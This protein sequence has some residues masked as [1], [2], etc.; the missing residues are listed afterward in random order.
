MAGHGGHAAPG[1]GVEY[2]DVSDDA[3]LQ[4]RSHRDIALANALFGGSRAVLA[5]FAGILPSAGGQVTLLDVG[6]GTGDIPARLA[7]HAA[8][9]G[10]DLRVCGLDGRLELVRANR[11]LP[12]QGVCADAL[13]LPFASASFDVVVASQL[14]HH[15]ARGDAVRLVRELNWVAKRRVIISDLR[16]SRAAAAGLWLVSFPLGFHPV[17]RHDGVV[18]IRRG[19]RDAELAALVREAVG[20]EPRIS[21]RFAWRLTACWEPACTPLPVH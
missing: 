11:E 15:F 13:A 18:S 21:R 12:A 2:L 14:V 8:R 9:Q 5:E 7:R 20:V 4:R 1:R 19:F 17:S 10:V 16:R 6:T 3:G